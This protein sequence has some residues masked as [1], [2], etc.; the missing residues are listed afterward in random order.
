[1][2]P[3]D[4]KVVPIVW[5]VPK[6][7]PTHYSTHLVVQHTDEEFTITFWDL[8]PP[9]LMGA[10]EEKRQQI[11]GTEGGPTHGTSADCGFAAT[12]A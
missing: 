4:E 2:D 9:V 11:Q 7:F 5:E 12:H 10:A 3:E 8:R 6:G 1:M